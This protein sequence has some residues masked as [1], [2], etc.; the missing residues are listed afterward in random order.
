MKV[1]DFFKR[2]KASLFT[3]AQLRRFINDDIPLNPKEPFPAKT[4][5]VVKKP[6]PK[7]V[8]PFAP[9]PYEPMPAPANK[10]AVMPS[11]QVA[12][13]SQPQQS[14]P[15][16]QELTP[17]QQQFATLLQRLYDKELNNELNGLDPI[18]KAEFDY[19]NFN[20]SFKSNV[21]RKLPPENREDMVVAMD[22]FLQ[23]LNK[24]QGGFSKNEIMS[25][26]RDG[27][28]NILNS[29]KPTKD[30]SPDIKS[31]HNK[32]L[33]EFG[34]QPTFKPYIREFLEN[35]AK[36]QMPG[37]SSPIMRQVAVP[38]KF[39][40]LSEQVVRGLIYFE[41]AEKLRTW[42]HFLQNENNEKM[43]DR[44]VEDIVK[45]ANINREQLSTN[46]LQSYLGLGGG[47]SNNSQANLRRFYQLFIDNNLKD[48]NIDPVE[49]QRRLNT[50]DP[51][52]PNQ[53]LA[54][55]DIIKFVNSTLFMPDKY[56]KEYIVKYML[57][58]KPGELRK[59]LKQNG[60]TPEDIASIMTV[61]GEEGQ[62]Q[63]Q[64]RKDQGINTSRNQQVVRP[65]LKPISEYIDT[66]ITSQDEDFFDWCAT[67]AYR[68]Y[69]R[70]MQSI[71]RN[72]PRTKG[73]NGE[74]IAYD[75][76]DEDQH[77]FGDDS[78]D[79]DNDRDEFAEQNSLG[80]DEGEEDVKRVMSNE[81]LPAEEV[82]PDE[83]AT[84]KPEQLTSFFDNYKKIRALYGDI[85]TAMDRQ[86]LSSLS[87]MSAAPQAKTDEEGGEEEGGGS[88]SRESL[89]TIL[90]KQALYKM[91]FSLSDKRMADF[92]GTSHNGIPVTD[93]RL[94]SIIN[95][96][97]NEL[98]RPYDLAKEL[99][100]TMNNPIIAQTVQRALN[101]GLGLAGG[102]TQSNTPEGMYRAIFGD[103][104]K[105]DAA[106]LTVRM[107]IR[108]NN[109][110]NLLLSPEIAGKHGKEALV[111]F[112]DMVGMDKRVIRLGSLLSKSNA[113]GINDKIEYLTELVRRGSITDFTED[114]IENMSIDELS[115][116]F[117]RVRR[118]L[119]GFYGN[120]AMKRQ[121]IMDSPTITDQDIAEVG[122]SLGIRSKKD[123]QN[124]PTAKANA[125]IKGIYTSDRYEKIKMQTEEDESL[126]TYLKNGIKKRSETDEAILPKLGL[127]TYLDIDNLPGRRVQQIAQVYYPDVYQAF[128]AGKLKSVGESAKPLENTFKKTLSSY[129]SAN[130]K[131]L[132][133][134]GYPS[135]DEF[136]DFLKK[137]TGDDLSKPMEKIL[138]RSGELEQMK[139]GPLR[140]VMNTYNR[141]L[142]VRDFSQ[143]PDQARLGV[144]LKHHI[145]NN[146]IKPD[147]T[148]GSVP[149]GMLNQA[150]VFAKI[151]DLPKKQVAAKLRMLSLKK[152]ASQK[153]YNAL[154]QLRYR[155]A[156]RS[157]D[158]TMLDQLIA[159]VLEDARRFD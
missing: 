146:L 142:S 25:L 9:T 23:K 10:P 45:S 90:Q 36:E 17:R 77:G 88:V 82:V 66:L 28:T 128:R 52:S 22:V 42:P 54:V 119:E 130:P 159:K 34:T 83:N 81:G 47:Q 115:S 117:G 110:E 139:P 114:Q 19:D 103:P 99:D 27:Y 111:S 46:F 69:G 62:E 49:I 15:T 78:D 158:T 31:V 144:A 124:A 20:R 157:V 29:T 37:E 39:P 44:I 131:L 140:E 68:D 51:N 79:V 70:G 38:N 152:I 100:L 132:Q 143:N 101:D 40:D 6:A 108:L 155:F 24:D 148:K 57:S 97:W 1:T 76:A 26:L 112:L 64:I 93:T 16:E 2:I 153:R 113:A 84:V 151:L 133:V 96:D 98:V 94:L 135:M 104:G 89:L 91:L 149:T 75:F 107:W 35:I 105:Q 8:V 18:E 122:A 71:T 13:I 73:E 116:V 126:R 92:F 21:L 32:F 125:V 65:Y 102:K 145:H 127:D 95:Q 30:G 85:A 150:L 59:I 14:Q 53:R 33:R 147:E 55:H 123:F 11:P 63:V 138:S 60:A 3:E 86:Y 121:A 154:V 136:N 7:A 134:L 4:P 74:D 118:E 106:N 50:V 87:K 48:K 129:V 72:A 61:Q 12:P 120:S 137:S 141:Y 41:G 56:G 58:R 67:E 156:Q 80:E 109:F 43:L 5:P